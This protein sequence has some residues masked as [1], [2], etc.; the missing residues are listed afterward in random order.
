MTDAELHVRTALCEAARRLL[1]L[2][3]NVGTAGNL[4]VR[5]DAGFWITPSGLHPEQ[6]KAEDIVLLDID[7]GTAGTQRPSSEWQIHRDLYRSRV[8]VGAVVH[9]HSPN[10]TALSCLRLPLPPFHYTIARFGGDDVP[11][12]DY[13]P[14]ATTALSNIVVAAMRDRSACLMANHGA[15]VIGATLDEAIDQAIELEFLCEL[16]LRARQAGNPV[17]L[18][19]VE[20]QQVGARYRNYCAQVD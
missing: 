19:P 5:H 1:A 14:F 10:A 16:Y 3:L 8:E 17:L 15:T 12:A 11:C 4:S 13:A 6:M 2:R 9:M 18:D 20:M 7:G